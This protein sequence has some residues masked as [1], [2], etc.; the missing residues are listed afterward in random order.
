[1]NEST[2]IKGVM[3]I[4]ALMALGMV[5][6]VVDTSLKS[7]LLEALP[8]L[9]EEPWFNTTIV[10]FYFNVAIVGA[11]MWYKERQWY[12]KI[13]WLVSFVCLG[14]IATCGYVALQCWVC[15]DALSWDRVLLKQRGDA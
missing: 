2:T 5:A 15:R 10:D 7:N 3:G 9:T 12:S 1:M 6:L 8:R 13:V 14:S 4:F 11:W